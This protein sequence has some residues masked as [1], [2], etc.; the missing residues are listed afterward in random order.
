LV[1]NNPVSDLGI[2]YKSG[3]AEN[4]LWMDVTVFSR[5]SET[6]PCFAVF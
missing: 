5:D 4:P 1:E 2:T 6:M 3:T